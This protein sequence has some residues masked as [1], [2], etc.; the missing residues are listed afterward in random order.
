M[1]PMATAGDM[2]NLCN[3]GDH[4]QALVDRHIL[5]NKIEPRELFRSAFLKKFGRD[6]PERSLDE[7]VKNYLE[8]GKTPGYIIDF[9]IGIYG[10]H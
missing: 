7:D 10:V 9:M 6:M 1:R 2:G 5:I 8:N 3:Q 4:M